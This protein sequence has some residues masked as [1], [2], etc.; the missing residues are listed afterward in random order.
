M[1][2]SRALIPPL[3]SQS[4]PAIAAAVASEVVIGLYLVLRLGL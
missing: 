3:P 2:Q 1:H 4:S